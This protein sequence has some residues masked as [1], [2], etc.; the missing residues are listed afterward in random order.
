MLFPETKVFS[1]HCQCPLYWNIFLW[2]YKYFG[3]TWTFWKMKRQKSSTERAAP[4]NSAQCLNFSRRRS[5]IPAAVPA[6][7]MSY[8][9][10]IR[11]ASFSGVPIWTL[12][13]VL[14]SSKNP[15]RAFWCSG[16]DLRI[17]VESP[18]KRHISLGTLVCAAVSGAYM[19]ASCA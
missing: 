8:D 5:Y 19:E 12:T 9:V 1:W 7:I 18:Q 4:T 3:I 14:K 13:F 17:V 15:S 6:S 16:A 2:G 10:F 11:P